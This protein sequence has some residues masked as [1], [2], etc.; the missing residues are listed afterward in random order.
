[1]CMLSIHLARSLHLFANPSP[2]GLDETAR[3]DVL[4]ARAVPQL[5]TLLG[6]DDLHTRRHAAGAL[7]GLTTELAAKEQVRRRGR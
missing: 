4:H 3:A 2:P 1:M 5:V 6:A 7:M